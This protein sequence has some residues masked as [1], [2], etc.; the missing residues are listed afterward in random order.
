MYLSCGN[1]VDVHTSTEVEINRLLITPAT[2]YLNKRALEL[3]ERESYALECIDIL[4]FKN[5]DFSINLGMKTYVYGGVI[6]LLKF[7]W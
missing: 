4:T 7:V 1:K 2:L 6:C 3:H 5:M